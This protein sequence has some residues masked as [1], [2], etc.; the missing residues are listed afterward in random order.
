MGVNNK[1]K[2]YGL[3]WA[4]EVVEKGWDTIANE[5]TGL[6]SVKGMGALKCLNRRYGNSIYASSKSIL[7]KAVLDVVV[8]A[9]KW[10]SGALKDLEIWFQQKVSEAINGDGWFSQLVK[11]VRA[12]IHKTCLDKYAAVEKNAAKANPQL[13][14]VEV[15]INLIPKVFEKIKAW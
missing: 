14:L 11:M 15:G 8:P 5:K 9:A 1:N 13:E 3:T 7:A 6:V 10:L 4:N 12:A 2:T